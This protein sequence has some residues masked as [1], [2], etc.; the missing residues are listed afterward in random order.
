DKVVMTYTEAGSGVSPNTLCSAFTT[1]NS[2]QSTSAAVTISTANPSALTVA[3]CTL[4][5][6]T[7]GNQYATTSN[8]SF[9]TSTI[10]W[11]ASSQTLTIALGTRSGGPATTGKGV[12]IPRYTPANTI[13]DRAGNAM[14][15]TLF[16][17][18]NSNF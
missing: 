18:T 5:T 11:T 17:G 12:G 8:L 9:A 4:G 10:S 7:L 1:S 6:L 3:G 13:T 14:S 15:A 16:N 2:D